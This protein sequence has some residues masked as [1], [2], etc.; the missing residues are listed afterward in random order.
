MSYLASDGTRRW[1]GGRNFPEEEMAMQME[2]FA[3]TGITPD[4]AGAD[5]SYALKLQYERWNTKGLKASISI[6]PEGNSKPSGGFDVRWHDAKYIHVRKPELVNRI[7]KYYRDG[8]CISEKNTSVAINAI[9]TDTYVDSGMLENDI[10]S[11]P[12]CGGN[13]RIRELMEGCPYCG[14]RFMMQ[15]LFPKVTNFFTYDSDT[16]EATDKL[17]IGMHIGGVILLLYAIIRGLIEG[18]MA[19]VILSPLFYPM[20]MFMGLVA[21][22]LPFLV[23]IFY[24]ANKDISQYLGSKRSERKIEKKLLQYDRFFSYKLFEGQIFSFLKMALFSENVDN[25]A[26]FEGSSIPEK[27]KNLIDMDYSG[28]ISLKK[29]ELVGDEI[30]LTLGLNLINTYYVRRVK[31]KRE[32]VKLQVAKKINAVEMP[33]F[34]IKK[35][36]CRSCGGSFDATRQRICPYCKSTYDMKENNWVITEIFS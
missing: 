16:K 9:V 13:S 14:A 6:I 18:Q 8:K 20:G 26:C 15:D 28:S 12:S 10:Y 3:K 33:G 32:Q 24:R 19:M 17:K 1:H 5:L 29:I 36:E 25:L 31:Y 21:E 27:Y 34:S 11:C 22:A 30:R 35:V 7:I 4:I 23:Y 2:S